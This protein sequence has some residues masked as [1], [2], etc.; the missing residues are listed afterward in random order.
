[1][2]AQGLTTLLIDIGET[3]EKEIF[4]LLPPLGDWKLTFIARI[5]GKPESDILV[6]ADTMSGILDVVNRSLSRPETK[7]QI[8]GSNLR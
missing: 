2:N 4:P 3:M 8:R 6:T 5:E 1:M 7:T